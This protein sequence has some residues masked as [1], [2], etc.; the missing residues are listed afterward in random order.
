MWCVKNSVLTIIISLSTAVVAGE[1][2]GVIEYRNSYLDEAGDN[3]HRLAKRG[4]SKRF[5]YIKAGDYKSVTNGNWF[6]YQI[7]L[8]KTNKIYTKMHNKDGLNVVNASHNK[9]PVLDYSVSLD[10]GEV[11]GF[12]CDL[13]TIKT[14]KG[15][16]KYYFSSA[17]KLNPEFF[18]N[19]QN[20]NWDF[21]TSKTS[22][23]PLK[24]VFH[25]NNFTYESVAV[26]IVE[27]ALSTKDF[28]INK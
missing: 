28:E 14:E 10:Q 19:H 20:G 23:L 9:Y 15:V 2:E 24:M 11:L 25:E 8:S 21:Y 3:N 22:A 6:E 26:D 4:G 12:K 13:I 18:K 17:H 5:Y 1:F 7:Y 16:Y 27:K